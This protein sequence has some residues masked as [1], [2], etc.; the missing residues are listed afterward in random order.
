MVI[1]IK[2]SIVRN[3]NKN[4]LKPDYKT[5]YLHKIHC[6]VQYIA[7]TNQNLSLSLIY[8]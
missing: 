6:A 7:K 2:K 3:G 4:N 5:D 8:I 1:P